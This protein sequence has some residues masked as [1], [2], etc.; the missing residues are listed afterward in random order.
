MRD[1]VDADGAAAARTIVDDHLL[2]HRLEIFLREHA[3]NQI[4]TAAGRERHDQADRA[5]GVI[6]A[7]GGEGGYRNSGH[8]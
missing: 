2:A 3:R 4:G 8:H 7:F 6:V 1:D 5:F